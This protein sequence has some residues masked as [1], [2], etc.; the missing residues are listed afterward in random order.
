MNDKHLQ[1]MIDEA[2]VVLKNYP[3]F[4]VFNAAQSGDLWINLSDKQKKLVEKELRNAKGSD[5]A[6]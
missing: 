3:L 5:P 4:R 1:T 2:K 6:G